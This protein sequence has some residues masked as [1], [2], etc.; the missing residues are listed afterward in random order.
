MRRRDLNKLRRLDPRL[1]AQLEGV[2][3]KRGTDAPSGVP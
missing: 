3:E 2:M 1:A